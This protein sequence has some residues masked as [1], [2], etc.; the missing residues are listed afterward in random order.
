MK[1]D[2]DG[3]PYHGHIDTGPTPQGSLPSA[4]SANTSSSNAEQILTTVATPRETIL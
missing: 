4:F 3:N 1:K 2:L